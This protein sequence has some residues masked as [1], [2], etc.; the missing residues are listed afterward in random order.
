MAT[1]HN[2][3]H[4]KKKKPAKYHFSAKP[5]QAKKNKK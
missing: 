2:K 5:G 4:Y 3:N 1:A